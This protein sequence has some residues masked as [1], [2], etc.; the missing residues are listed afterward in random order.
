MA[1]VPTGPKGIKR[2]KILVGFSLGLRICS[3]AFGLALVVFGLQAWT[4][5]TYRLN[6]IIDELTPLIIGC[7]SALFLFIA[8]LNGSNSFSTPTPI[9]YRLRIANDNSLLLHFSY[10]PLSSTAVPG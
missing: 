1:W 5:C 3:L 2:L 4:C 6:D 8:F 7:E 9:H 10:P